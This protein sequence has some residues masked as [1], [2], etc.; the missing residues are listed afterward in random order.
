MD[1]LLRIE[2]GWYI[3]LVSGMLYLVSRRT[4]SG[5][6]AGAMVLLLGLGLWYGWRQAP[7]LWAAQWTVYAAGILLLWAWL[8]LD[9]PLD[10]LPRWQAESALVVLAWLSWTLSEGLTKATLFYPL[11]RI[12]PDLA[13]IGYLW[14]HRWAPLFVWLS[15][16][17]ALVWS[18]IATLWKPSSPSKPF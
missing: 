18:L 5:G 11:Q 13:D 17:L 16:L 3:A 6:L 1:T 2:I 4:V 9:R 14:T 7:Y 15:L 8:A 12:L 10:T